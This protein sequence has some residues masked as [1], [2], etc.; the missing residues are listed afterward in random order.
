MRVDLWDKKASFLKSLFLEQSCALTM[1]RAAY[2]LGSQ[3]REFLVLSLMLK[4]FIGISQKAWPCLW[5]W[6]GAGGGEISCVPC[7][8]LGGQVTF[9]DCLD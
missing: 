3:F 7:F 6:R 8:A 1:E 9:L 5:N 4:I 2:E